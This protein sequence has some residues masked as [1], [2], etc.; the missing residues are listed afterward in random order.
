MYWT[1]FL[2]AEDTVVNKVKQNICSCE[3]YIL[4]ARIRLISKHTHH[5][6]SVK[7]KHKEEAKTGPEILSLRLLLT[8]SAAIPSHGQ[9]SI[10]P[11]VV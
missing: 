7:A 6:S 3:L 1:L 9:C 4:K 11:S 2:S 5:V 8:S 10:E